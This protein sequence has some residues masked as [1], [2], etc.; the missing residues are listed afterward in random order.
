VHYIGKIPYL[1]HVQNLML[2]NILQVLINRLQK[3]AGYFMLAG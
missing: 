1:H 3:I 2:H